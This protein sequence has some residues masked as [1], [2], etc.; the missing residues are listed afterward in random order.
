LKTTSFTIIV[1]SDGFF[2]KMK[3]FFTKQFS[4]FWIKIYINF[5]LN[6]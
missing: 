2:F 1:L 5:F 4:I 6:R 3:L